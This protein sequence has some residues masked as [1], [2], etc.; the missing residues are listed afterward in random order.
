[1]RRDGISWRIVNL[2]FQGSEFSV[3][4]NPIDKTYTA[5]TQIK[6]L[7]AALDIYRLENGR[8]PTTIQGL[9][10]LVV[11]KSG[12][13]A[14]NGPYLNKNVIPKDPWGFEYKY[15]SPGVHGSF[16]LYSLGADNLMGGEGEN[17]DI[18]GWEL[19]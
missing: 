2:D 3:L 19:K 10:S 1:M 13:K 11:N 18:L 14:W 4:S 17:Q 12:S 6:N 9:D 7:S 15:Q 5:R 8:Y 16:D